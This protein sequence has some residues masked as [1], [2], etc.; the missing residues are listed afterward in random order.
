MP[1]DTKDTYDKAG[2][3]REHDAI[4]AEV[5]RIRDGLSKDVIDYYYSRYP[6]SEEDESDIRAGMRKYLR[7]ASQRIDDLLNGKLY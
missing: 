6:S 7:M 1:D 5:Q 4:I 3:A 2:A